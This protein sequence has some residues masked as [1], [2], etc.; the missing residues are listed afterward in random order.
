MAMLCYV[1]ICLYLI[2]VDIFVCLRGQFRGTF[3]FQRTR[4]VQPVIRTTNGPRRLFGDFQQLYLLIENP[5][6]Y[7]HEIQMKLQTQFGVTVSLATICRT[8]R[9]MGCTIQVVRNVALEQSEILRASWS[10]CLQPS[11]DLD[12]WEWLWYVLLHKKV[13]IQ[14]TRLSTGK[15]KTSSGWC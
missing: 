3:P 7:L 6:M 14:P 2:I 5:T 4:D 9:L 13:W 1:I 8:L 15:N 11:V 10:F 12:W